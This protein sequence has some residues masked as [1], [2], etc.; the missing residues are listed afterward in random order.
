MSRYTGPKEKISR[1]L[2]V[3]L[4]LKPERSFGP[5]SAFL[6][7][8]YPPGLHGRT[9]RRRR[10][11]G[12]DFGVHLAE[13]QKV[14]FSYGITESQLRR[15]FNE[16]R[17]AKGSTASKFYQLLERRLDNVISRL[18]IAISRATAR[19]LIN[20]GHFEVNGKRVKSPSF[21]VNVGDVIKIKSS[22]KSKGVFR[23]LTQRLKNF[24]VQPWLEL[25]KEFFEGKVVALP[26]VEEAEIPFDMQLLVE[27][28]S[29]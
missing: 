4:G 29:R 28:Y 17:K 25:N 1:R 26:I 24:E 12:S 14:R 10:G 27:F 11:G 3:N 21:S 22:S 16:A 7:R 2:G 6:R 20:H 23:D 19:Q 15:Y 8:S 13:K 5:K 18:G 9:R